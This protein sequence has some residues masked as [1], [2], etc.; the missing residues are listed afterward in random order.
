ML[1]LKNSIKLKQLLIEMKKKS[2]YCIISLLCLSALV[3]CSENNQ[4]S[5]VGSEYFFSDSYITWYYRMDSADLLLDTYDIGKSTF[6]F[7]WQGHFT[8]YYT[9][10]HN[11]GEY[12]RFCEKFGDF[13]L[14]SYLD[15]DNQ[16][17][18]N[19]FIGVT[20]TSSSDFPGHPA[21]TNLNDIAFIDL[22]S[23]KPF[24]DS[25]YSDS[26]LDQHPIMIDGHRLIAESDGFTPIYK[27]AKDLKREDLMLIGRNFHIVFH[28]KPLE[29]NEIVYITVTLEQVGVD[30]IVSTYGV[31]FG[32]LAKK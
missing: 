2:Y 24:I 12:T 32:N 14:N 30:P 3:S 21:G 7:V 29:D 4:E 28:D 6:I 27:I 19:D 8:D 17:S 22:V 10:E 15:K 16:G 26:Y 25:R 11:S 9:K 20:I 1:L 23:A 18:V 31:N 5:P 13:G